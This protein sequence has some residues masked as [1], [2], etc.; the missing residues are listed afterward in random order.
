M[1]ILTLTTLF[2]SSTQPLNA[3][4]V[5]TR[6]ERFTRRHGHRWT[7]VA[8]VPW[9]PRL[10]FKVSPA[11][12]AFAR[13]P[14]Y[15]DPWGYPL[16]HPRYLVTPKVGMSRYGAWMAAGV[17]G[18]VRR[19][20]ARD[21]F[22]AIDGH[23]IY[24]DGTAAVE[25]GKELGLP[26]VL[27]ARGTD[28]NL[29][30]S[31]PAIAPLIKANLDGCSHLVC[32]CNELK[33]VALGLGMPAARISVIGNGVDANRFSRGDRADSR[34]ALGLP[35]DATLVLSVGHMTERKGFHLL[36]EACA[37]IRPARPGLLLV[38]AGDGPQRGE[39]ER[40]AEASG[41][42]DGVRFA[43]AVRN[44]SLPAWYQAADLF[45]LASSREGWPNVLCEA[46][47]CGLPAVA[48][49][50]WGIPEIVKDPS[51]GVL[52]AERSAEGLMAGLEEALAR[53]WDRAHIEAVGRARTWDAVAD[54]LVPV[55]AS[56]GRS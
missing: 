48:T 37:R 56:L 43:G 26:V 25:L 11:Y 6:M 45:A 2:P 4:F 20:H 1:N 13:T 31:M 41:L 7:V 49:R 34:R 5:R 9:F 38:I 30:P 28:L 50:V 40:L 29:Y 46:Q 10:P 42:G 15:E 12:D 33:D 14:A 47:A 19:L 55:F 16:Y 23:Y 52:V 22:D 3:V 24:P 36:I 53:P 32:V 35:A 39:L 21:P 27:S 8:P 51:L 18:L 17:R 44:E 54:E